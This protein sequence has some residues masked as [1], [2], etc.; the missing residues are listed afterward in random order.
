M[1][2]FLTELGLP[3]EVVSFFFTFFIGAIAVSAVTAFVFLAVSTM[4]STAIFA[5]RKLMK[6]K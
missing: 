2:D 1:F 4:I 5:N 6:A 3:E